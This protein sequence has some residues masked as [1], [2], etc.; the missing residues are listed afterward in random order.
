MCMNSDFGSHVGPA[1][2]DKAMQKDAV[3]KSSQ[4]A[5]FPFGRSSSAE[6]ILSPVGRPGW[7]N[8]CIRLSRHLGG[9]HSAKLVTLRTQPVETTFEV[10]TNTD[11]RIDEADLMDIP[12]KVK[13]ATRVQ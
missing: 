4:E 1:S 5:F 10:D 6:Q 9:Q 7:S 8:I 13:Q 3:D 12:I 11:S 2:L